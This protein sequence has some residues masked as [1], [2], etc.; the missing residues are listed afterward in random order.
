M[1]IKYLLKFTSEYQYARDLIDGKLFM[2]QAAYF[3]DL[4]N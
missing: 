3:H 1:E 2:N 4:E